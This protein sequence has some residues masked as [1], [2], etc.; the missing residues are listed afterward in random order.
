MDLLHPR[1]DER[2]QHEYEKDLE[3]EQRDGGSDPE[4]VYRWARLCHALYP[5]EWL[6]CA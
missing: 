5:V 3:N 1:D 4:L 2:Q 6:A